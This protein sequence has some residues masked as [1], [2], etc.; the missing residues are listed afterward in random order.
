MECIC[1]RW[2]VRRR[3]ITD[4]IPVRNDLEDVWNVGCVI[5]LKNWKLGRETGNELQIGNNK[6]WNERDEREY[7]D[8]PKPGM[9]GH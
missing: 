1:K 7:V 5:A 4:W 3:W 2:N 6:H 8:G 9:I